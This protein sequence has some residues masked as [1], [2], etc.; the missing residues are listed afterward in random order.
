MAWAGTIDGTPDALPVID[1]VDQV[2]GLVVATGMSGHG[3]GIAPAVG[4]IV[5]DLVTCGSSSHDLN[6]FR[7]RRFRDGAAKAAQHLL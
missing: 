6:P 3:F 2:S 4:K 7:L 1:A 5:A